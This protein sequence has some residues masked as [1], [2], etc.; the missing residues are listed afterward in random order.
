M[1]NPSIA[2]PTTGYI[3]S[4]PCP[5]A[6][7][8]TPPHTSKR[9]WSE[10]STCLAARRVV[11]KGSA[12]SNLFC[13]EWAAPSPRSPW[14]NGVVRSFITT[15]STSMRCR[16]VTDPVLERAWTG[17]LIATASGAR[18]R[19]WR[20]RRQLA[21]PPSPDELPG[22]IHLGLH[23]NAEEAPA[24]TAKPMGTGSET[25][26]HLPRLPARWGWQWRLWHR[27]RRQ[28]G[29]DP[30]DIGATT[31]QRQPKSLAVWALSQ[32]TSVP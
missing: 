6:A 29:W 16:P 13:E 19:D 28:C 11:L 17:P 8:P 4:P 32:R 10:D 30:T 15:W 26:G 22:T 24:R 7:P 31:V 3:L 18:H 14:Q 23:A 20:W 25:T 27:R 12:W 21:D 5:P 2:D 9:P 1:S